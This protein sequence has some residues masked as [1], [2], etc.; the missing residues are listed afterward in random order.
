MKKTL[1]ITGLLILANASG[2]GT[3]NNT[4]ADALGG[5]ILGGLFGAAIGAATRNP[6]AIAI[7]AGAGAAAGAGLGA[8]A[9]NAQ[10]RADQHQADAVAQSQANIRYALEHPA[11]PPEQIAKM[12]RD[13][14]SD[15]I[16]IE[17]I[18]SSHSLYQ[19]SPDWI[20]WLKSQ[21][22][23]DRVILYMQQT[24]S[25]VQPRYVVVQ[26]APPPPGGVV[27][28][29]GGFYGPRRWGYWR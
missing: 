7:G 18:R 6:A 26:P 16:I 12:A 15:E 20:T 17:Q 22:V 11:L 3:M 10:D 21:G 1:W 5:G 23:S 4:Q 14:I 8:V 27:V 24:L 19:L 2:C 9:G 29:G 13:R 25:T 28:I